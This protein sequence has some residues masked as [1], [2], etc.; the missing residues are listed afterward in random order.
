MQ[1][2]FIFRQS[3]IMYKKNLHIFFENLEITDVVLASDYKPFFSKCKTISAEL[4]KHE[5]GQNEAMG[6]KYS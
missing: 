3:I 5:R 1:I 2:N 6:I 4:R